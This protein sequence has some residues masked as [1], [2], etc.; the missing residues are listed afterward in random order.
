M[1]TVGERDQWRQMCNFG[2]GWL[3]ST[4]E[5]DFWSDKCDG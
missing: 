2:V 4:K 5:A 3:V 1:F